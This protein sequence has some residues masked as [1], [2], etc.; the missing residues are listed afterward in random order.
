MHFEMILFAFSI[1][2]IISHANNMPPPGVD[3]GNLSEEI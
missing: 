3:Q 1:Y 2:P